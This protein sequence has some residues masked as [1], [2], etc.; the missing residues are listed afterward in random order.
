MAGLI[1]IDLGVNPRTISGQP[2]GRIIDMDARPVP[3]A[4]ECERCGYTNNITPPVYFEDPGLLDIIKGV[5]YTIPSGQCTWK[6]SQSFHD[7][8]SCVD[9]MGEDQILKIPE[10]LHTWLIDTVKKYGPTGILRVD[11]IM[12][13][14]ALEKLKGTE[15]GKH[16]SETSGRGKKGSQ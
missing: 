12:I 9:E 11:T 14:K 6:D 3:M 15:G 5:I 13:V 1:K 8:M 10:S 2:F 7:L 16:E 4:Y